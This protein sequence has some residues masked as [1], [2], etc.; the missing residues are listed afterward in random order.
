MSEFHQLARP[1][2]HSYVMVCSH[3]SFWVPVRTCYVR[4]LILEAISLAISFVI[5]IL[6]HACDEGL[7][8]AANLNLETWHFI[9]VW[10]TFFLVCF[11]LGVYFLQLPGKWSSLLRIVWFVVI[12]LAVSYDRFSLPL[13]GSLFVTPAILLALRYAHPHGR[14]AFVV[15]FEPF[16]FLVGM[17]VFG[18][19][20]IVFVSAGEEVA[21]A[22]KLHDVSKPKPANVPDT[23]LY[24]MYHGLWHVLCM[25]ST[26]FVVMA[27]RDF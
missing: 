14:K 7:Y 3:F 4:G 22:R 26:H 9:D 8:C 20:L 17:S 15:H 23:T 16:P 5:S 12:T 6:Y 27:K 2:W 13:M 25:I 10:C 21:G 18:V 1:S 11:V 24:W 19:A